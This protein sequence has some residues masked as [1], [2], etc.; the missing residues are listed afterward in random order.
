MALAR[1]ETRASDNRCDFDQVERSVILLSRNDPW[2]SLADPQG[3]TTRVLRCMG[4]GAPN[5]LAD[6]RL[7]ALR[8]H[9]IILRPGAREEDLQ[10]LLAAGFVAAQ[11]A[12]LE[13]M[14]LPWR[15]RPHPGPG[16]L[17]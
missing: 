15:S 17:C 11:A 7:E 14:V 5:R 16:V 12:R 2:L 4:F 13:Q 10:R 6:A 3:R 8:R 9:A 1:T